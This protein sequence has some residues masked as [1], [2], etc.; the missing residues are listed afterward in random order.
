MSKQT[1]SFL[2]RLAAEFIGTAFLLATVVGS[3]IMGETLAGGNVAL[4]LLGNTIATGAILVVLILIFGPLSGAHFNP[5]VTLSFLL[6]REI[7]AG[8]ALVYVGVQVAAAICGAMAAHIM[9]AEPVLMISTH[10]RTGV[11]QW[12]AEFIATFGLVATILGC[13]RFRPDAVPY[14]VGL[15]ITAGYWFTASTSFANPAVTIARTLT[16]TFSGIAPMDAPGFI[17]AQLVGAV[18]AT[19]VFGWLLQPRD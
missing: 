9:F 2:R 15:F 10:A 11:G 12:F 7:T 19:L 6:R 13:V 17:A 5:A 14:A 4:A 3:G 1:F 16:D 18:A 8:E